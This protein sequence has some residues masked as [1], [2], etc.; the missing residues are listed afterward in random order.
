MLVMGR[1]QFATQDDAGIG[2]G[3]PPISEWQLD[4]NAPVND[5]IDLIDGHLDEAVGNVFVRL[6]HVF[7]RAQQISL[8]AT[9][10]H[11]LTC[12]V[13]HRLLLC[14]P[15]VPKLDTSTVTEC[16]RYAIILFMFVIQGPTYYSHAVL[17]DTMIG[18][19]KQNLKEYRSTPRTQDSLLVWILTAGMA[20][21]IGTQHYTFFVEAAQEASIVMQLNSWNDAFVHIE[22][23]LWLARPDSESIFRP[24]WEFVLGAGEEEAAAGQSG[25][26]SNLPETPIERLGINSIS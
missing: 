8:P 13:I 6:R 20:A 14:A 5:G 16:L 7:Q 17:L 2:D 3:I 10:L 11:D 19:L 26:L 9:Q 18:H 24:H 15:S 25:P 21:S 4:I 12:F 22:R 23:V 1:P